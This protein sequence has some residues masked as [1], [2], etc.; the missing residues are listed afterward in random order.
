MEDRA[1]LKKILKS[2]FYVALLVLELEE[3]HLLWINPVEINSV[4]HTWHCHKMLFK[5]TTQTPS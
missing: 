1:G 2:C 4:P 3:I 5:T